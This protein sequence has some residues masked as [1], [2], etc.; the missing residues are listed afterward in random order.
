MSKPDNFLSP[1]DERDVVEAI[2][3]AESATSGEIRVHLE[4]TCPSTPLARAGEVFNLLKMDQTELRNGVLIYVATDDHLFY[5]CGDKA[6]NDVVEPD[7]WDCTKD[8]M[9]K[10]FKNHDHKQALID[11]IQRAGEQLQKYFPRL[12]GDKDE[13]SNEISNG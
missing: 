2:R 5:I 4:R 6:I 7:F 3:N 12:E 11:G 8:V 1:D 13:L 9:V 10:H